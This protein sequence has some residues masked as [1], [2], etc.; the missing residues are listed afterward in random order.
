M[1]K[2]ITELFSWCYVMWSTL[3]ERPGDGNDQTSSGWC[4]P[5]RPSSAELPAAPGFSP[6]CFSAGTRSIIRPVVE[7]TTENKVGMILNF[8]LVILFKKCFKLNVFNIVY[9]LP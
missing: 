8:H 4:R 6:W 3:R 9:L 7:K 1:M 2:R 5:L